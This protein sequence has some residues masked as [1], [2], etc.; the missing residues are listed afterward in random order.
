MDHNINGKIKL[1]IGRFTIELKDNII[2]ALESKK[3][4]TTDPEIREQLSIK[5][6]DIIGS[7]V[8]FVKPR[9]LRN[10]PSEPVRVKETS[11]YLKNISPQAYKRLCISISKLLRCKSDFTDTTFGS[12][13]KNSRI[14]EAIRRLDASGKI[15]QDLLDKLTE[16]AENS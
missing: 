2:K 10:A 4:Q 1:I 14:Y 8:I 13:P 6:G 11:L 7:E 12:F 16:E 3:Q 9:V 5:I 15:D